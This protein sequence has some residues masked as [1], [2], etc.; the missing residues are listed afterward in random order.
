[1][2]SRP[3]APKRGDQ[4]LAFVRVRFAER[5]AI[6]R[7]HEGLRDRRRTRIAERPALG[8]VQP[9]GFEIGAQ[10]L[11]DRRGRVGGQNPRDPLAPFGRTLRLRAR[12]IESPRPGMGVDETERAFLARQI[13]EDAGQNGVLEHVGKIAGMKGVTIVDRN[14]PSIQSAR[15][16]LSGD[17]ASMSTTSLCFSPDGAREQLEAV[18]DHFTVGSACG[19]R[20]LK[21]DAIG[22]DAQSRAFQHGRHAAGKSISEQDGAAEDLRP[23]AFRWRQQLDGGPQPRR[24]RS[25]DVTGMNGRGDEDALRMGDADKR[26]LE[27]PAKTLFR[28]EIGCVPPG[29]IGQGADGDP[30][31]LLSRGFAWK[32]TFGP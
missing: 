28:A 20:H 15:T 31:P 7:A 8:V 27:Q 10:E 22:L 21:P 32:K 9:D 23:A 11:G 2:L 3:I 24:V 26:K 5:D 16:Y 1:M 12:Q 6:L 19:C 29:D 14:D 25:A 18:A 4:G 13:N 30:Q 17:G